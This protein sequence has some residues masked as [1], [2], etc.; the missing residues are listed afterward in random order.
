MGN[1]YVIQVRS[2]MEEKIKDICEKL[3]SKDILMSSFIPKRRLVK[4]IHG[5]WEEIEEILFSGYVFLVSDHPEELYSELKK[6]PDLTKLLGKIEKEFFPL[7]EDEIIF[8]KSMY[9]EENV[10]HMSEGIIENDIVKITN[11]PLKG[12]EGMIAKID[13]HK[14]IAFIEVELFGKITQAK[15]GLE[16]IKKT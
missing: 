12:K 7:Y 4:K 9:D 5:K 1:W 16:I 3:I 11:G 13:R 2:R 15:V 8:L 6:V 10:V 14:R